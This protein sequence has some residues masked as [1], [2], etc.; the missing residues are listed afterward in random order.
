MWFE[1]Y[2]KRSMDRLTPEAWE[3]LL[4]ADRSGRHVPRTILAT[5]PCCRTPVAVEL[6]A[7]LASI[8]APS[9]DPTADTQ[10]ELAA[11]TRT[12]LVPA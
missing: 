6:T 8:P 11:V 3:K 1:A 12:D 4:T 7:A 10:L 9:A 5:C 2:L